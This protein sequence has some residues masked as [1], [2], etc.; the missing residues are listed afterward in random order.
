MA[1]QTI[2]RR[3]LKKPRTLEI[4]DYYGESRALVSN[5][6]ENV[7][8]LKDLLGE[9]SDLNI[10]KF[11]FGG[12]KE[13]VLVYISG[14][15]QSNIIQSLIEKLMI[16]LPEFKEEYF[17]EK[18][19]IDWL[20]EVSIP[21]TH[22]QTIQD[23]KFLCKVLLEGDAAILVDGY[24]YGLGLETKGSEDRGIN[25]SQTESVIRG[26]KDS[27]NESLSTN[28]MLIRRRIKDINLRIIDREIGAA[29]KTRVAVM[30]LE[31]TANEEVI[32]DLIRRLDLIDIDGILESS[33]IEELILDEPKSIFPT[34]QKTERP[35][36]VVANLLEGRVTVLVDGTPV[37]LILP[38]IFYQFFHSVEDYYMRPIFATFIRFIRFGAFFISLLLP[39]IYI[40]LTTFHQEMIPTI[41]LINIAGQREIVPLPALVEAFLMAFTFE[42]LREAGLRMPKMIGNAI[43]IVGAL[44][45]GE[46]AVNAGIVSN[47]MVIVVAFTAIT[48]LI[49]PEHS[50]E[51]PIRVLRFVFI[52]LAGMFG[53]FGVTIGI[54]S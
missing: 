3:K 30:Y 48:T 43:S 1:L 42:T 26:P 32:H 40:S 11:Y 28:I 31:G 4:G 27:F 16:D 39:A 33:Y 13:M 29:T 46:G 41:L 22:V 23:F 2:F 10:R 18:E 6:T 38:A 21:V 20:K 25:E 12:K 36:R 52:A 45:I 9:P 37:A 14:I 7:N 24:S 5:L 54:F 44:V 35:D 49:F 8:I 34:M 17:E 47:I 50:I 53:L 15:S 51:N 19:L